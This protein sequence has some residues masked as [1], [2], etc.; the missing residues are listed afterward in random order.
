MNIFMLNIILLAFWG[1]V[2]RKSLSRV[3]ARR[4]GFII[5]VTAQLALIALFSPLVSDAANYAYHASIGWYPFEPGWNLC[6][7]I[8]WGIWPDGKSLMLFANYAFLLSFARFVWKRSENFFVSYLVMICLGIWGMTFFI[9]RQTVALA[10]MLFAYDALE[11]RR[12][13]LF[14]ALVLLAATFHT[15]ALAFVPVYP[16]LYVKRDAIYLLVFLFIGFVCILFG[17]ELIRLIL[18]F[19]RNDYEVTELS[20]INLLLML[21]AFEVLIEFFSGKTSNQTQLRAFDVG[22]VFQ[23]LSLRLSNLTRATKYF[24][25]SLC[26]LIPNMFRKVEDRRQRLLIALVSCGALLV[27]YFLFD[28][29]SFPGGPSA[30]EITP[31][32]V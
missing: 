19:S 10:I 14:I 3:T 25:V 12:P 1:L 20:G 22:L 24:T 2:F 17:P 15:T 23:S 26:T 11:E 27:F 30:Y 18:V 6:S 9:L 13:F 4:P 29:C 21:L 31:P 8:L 28:N 5:V 32:L 7:S 16:L